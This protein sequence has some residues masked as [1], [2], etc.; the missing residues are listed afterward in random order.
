MW[1]NLPTTNAPGEFEARASNGAKAYIAVYQAQSI[2]PVELNVYGDA[3]PVLPEL[4]R[5]TY[6]DGV[7]GFAP[8][9]WDGYE[10]TV[11]G[12]GLKA[13]AKINKVAAD[14]PVNL[15]DASKFD[16][17]AT[18]NFT[19]S[20]HRQAKNTLDGRQ[21]TFWDNRVRTSAAFNFN[22]NVAKD[23]SLPTS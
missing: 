23:T 12:T 1:E 11:D 21:D 22:V 7:T 17:K 16:L 10:G 19:S 8:V 13:E 18:A 9:K 6:T 14:A 20:E 2:D 5:A 4:V 3:E 15:A